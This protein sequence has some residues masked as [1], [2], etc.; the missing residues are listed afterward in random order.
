MS[1]FTEGQEVT[2]TGDTQDY[3]HGFR[4]GATATVVSVDGSPSTYVEVDGT[5]AWVANLDLEAATP[6][7]FDPS[8]VKAGDTVTLER[9]RGRLPDQVVATRSMTSGGCSTLILEGGIEVKVTGPDA[10]TLTDHQPAPE[11]EPVDALADTVHHILALPNY[12]SS[13]ATAHV[14]EKI[15]ERF[16]VIDPADVDVDALAETVRKAAD[17]SPHIWY[18]AEIVRATLAELGI[19][20]S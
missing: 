4:A 15:R 12:E 18:M 9:D 3:G 10:W 16:V 20:A 2:V 19:E 17:Q 1:A 13:H 8:K 14:V 6:A 5:E 11:P 7:P